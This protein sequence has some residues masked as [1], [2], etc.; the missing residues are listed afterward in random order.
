M[1]VDRTR[2]AFTVRF[3]A[4]RCGDHC[5]YRVVLRKMGRHCFI[6]FRAQMASHVQAQT[7][8]I[9]SSADLRSPL[10][11]LLFCLTALSLVNSTLRQRAL[12]VTTLTSFTPATKTL[13][14][15][16]ISFQSLL[17]TTQQSSQP[18]TSLAEFPGYHVTILHPWGRTRRR[19]RTRRTSRLHTK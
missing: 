3:T 5:L 12:T 4:R 1:R 9:A 11:H 15:G 18:N 13:G 14:L 16:A 19:A 17:R 6:W 7:A 10:A 2:D 8:Y